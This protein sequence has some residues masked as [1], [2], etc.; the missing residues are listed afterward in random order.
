MKIQR[1]LI[2]E[3]P[4]T[5]IPTDH[6]SVKYYQ[7]ENIDQTAIAHNLEFD[8]R[9]SDD[10]IKKCCLSFRDKILINLDDDNLIAEDFLKIFSDKII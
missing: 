2:T 1:I 10:D 6:A 5:Y 3:K 4:S 9:W 8:D 7:H